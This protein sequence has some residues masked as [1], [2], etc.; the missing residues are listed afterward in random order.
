MIDSYVLYCAISII[1][2]SL[3]MFAVTEQFKVF[4]KE[5]NGLKN[6]RKAIITYILIMNLIVIF[7]YFDVNK[8]FIAAALMICGLISF[9]IHIGS[10]FKFLSFKN[11]KDFLS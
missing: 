1:A 11:W 5:I 4:R 10:E 7:L 9:F 8:I 2:V 3:F 6:M